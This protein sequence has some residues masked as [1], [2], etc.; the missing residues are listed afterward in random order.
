MVNKLI[1][2]LGKNSH[3]EILVKESPGMDKVFQ[4]F[5]HTWSLVTSSQQRTK[6]D[7]QEVQVAT[8]T[9]EATNQLMIP[10]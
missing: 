10:I 5:S 1:T 9:T 7:L 3:S 2:M 8:Q 6:A 4:R